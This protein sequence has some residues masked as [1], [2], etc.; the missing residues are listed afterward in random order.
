MSLLEIHLSSHAIER[1][2]QRV[3]PGLDLDSAG[4]ELSRLVAI[5]ELS[6]TAP[7][8]HAHR[9]AQEA[10]AYLIVADLVLP[11]QPAQDDPSALVAVSCIPRGGLSDAA[12]ARRN[13][14]RRSQRLRQRS[15]RRQS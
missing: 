5:G 11:L 1:F 13:G 12:R 2:H 8:W 7:P 3:R 6:D 14:R 15:A 10:H 4:D 9:Q